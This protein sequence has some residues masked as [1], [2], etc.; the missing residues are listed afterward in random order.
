MTLPKALLGQTGLEVSRLAYGSLTLGPVQTNM[1]PERGGELLAYAFAR[2]LNFVDTA[3]LY[4]TYPHIRS[5]LRKVSTPPVIATKCYA[6]DRASAEASFNLARRELDLDVIDLFL[7]HEQETT[8]TLDGHREAFAYF[9]EQKEKGLIRGVGISTHAVEPV[10][11][12]VQAKTRNTQELW[13]GLDSGLYHEAD[14]I[15]PMLNMK[16]L[17]LLDGTAEDM[18][19][20]TTAAAAAGLGIYGMKMLGGG[21]FLQDFDQA[22]AFAFEQLKTHVSSYAVGMQSEAEIDMNLSLFSGLPV[23]SEAL[24]ATR[25]RQR[26]LTIADWCTGCGN[27]VSRC[28]SG[29]LSLHPETGQAVVDPERCVLCGYCA[30][31]CRDF[32]LK[33]V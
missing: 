4:G 9:L 6:Y 27:C 26:R 10:R 28:S 18:V 15:H 25:S 21:H 5:A 8:L 20:A 30:Y 7:L 22:V 2:G 14:V 19:A 1:S 17:G 32:C 29:A 31:G 11:A 23:T 12:L 13:L 16:G 3:E 24:A 33:V